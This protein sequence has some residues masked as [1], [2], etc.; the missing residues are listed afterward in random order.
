LVDGPYFSRTRSS[1]RGDNVKVRW[2]WAVLLICVAQPRADPWENAV[3][4][5]I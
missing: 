2:Q 4:S 3:S 5:E 1:H